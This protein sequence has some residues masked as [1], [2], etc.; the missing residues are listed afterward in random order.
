MTSPEASIIVVCQQE[1][2]RIAL[3]PDLI[4][5]VIIRAASGSASV[6]ATMYHDTSEKDG[7]KIDK[8]IFTHPKTTLDVFIAGFGPVYRQFIATLQLI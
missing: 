3:T 1:I 7:S 2:P 4:E 5:S 8:I 6:S